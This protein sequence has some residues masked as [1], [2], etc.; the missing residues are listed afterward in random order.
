MWV[1]I[2]PGEATE[3]MELKHEIFDYVNGLISV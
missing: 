2:P 3:K 1:K